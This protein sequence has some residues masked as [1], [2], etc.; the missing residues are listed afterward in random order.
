MIDDPGDLNKIDEARSV[1]MA[2][3]LTF[4]VALREDILNYLDLA[5]GKRTTGGSTNITDITENLDSDIVE[6]SEDTNEVQDMLNDDAPIIVRMANKIIQEAY[7]K[8]VSDIHIEPYPGT[9]PAEVRYRRDGSC[10]KFTEI[11][12]NHIRALVNRIKI[13]AKLKVDEKRFPQSGKIKLKYGNKDVEL[14]VEV[15]PT[16]GGLEDVVMRILASGK[17]LPLEKMN[18]SEANEKN[19][20]EIAGKPYGLILVVGPT[21]SGKTTTLHSVL[22]FLNN[23]D[24][25]IWTAEDPVEITQFGLRQVQVNPNI[26][27]VPFDFALAM[28]SFLRADPDVIMVGEMRDKETASMGVEASLTGHLVL[29][30]LHT[31]SAPETITRLIDMGLNPVNFS[32]ALLGVLAQRLVKTLC[33]DCKESYTPSPGE[34]EEMIEE[35]GKEIATELGIKDLSALTLA[36][37]KGC[38]KC[39]NSGYRGR[40]GVHELLVGSKAIKSLIMGRASVE[41]I[42]KAAISEGMRTL[43][44]DGIKKV[45]NAQ[46]D[47]D[48]V[49][50][51]CVE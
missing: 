35:Y 19:L 22:G 10:T 13:M 48:Q 4:N 42:R 24:R 45:L 2:R 25:K 5:T 1:I 40:T 9:Q 6:M 34:V 44:M 41:E 30:T 8:G 33:A 3:D 49:R 18:F 47:I 43:R 36:R 38:D 51:V 7:E 15:T 39:G 26:K 12:A 21:G 31:N 46:T 14:R 16:V 17:P 11:P 23:P 32:D 20:R 27:P 28:R 29:S 50:R 37:P